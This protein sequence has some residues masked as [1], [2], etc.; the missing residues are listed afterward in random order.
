MHNPT[1]W[2]KEELRLESN[3]KEEHAKLYPGIRRGTRM[4]HSLTSAR[5]TRFPII[6][7]EH[8]FRLSFVQELSHL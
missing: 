6:L 7:S 5:A 3:I 4:H 1:V 2:R 8:L